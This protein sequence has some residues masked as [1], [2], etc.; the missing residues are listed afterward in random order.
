MSNDSNA[1][2]KDMRDI[3]LSLSLRT[4]MAPEALAV[5]L[6]ELPEHQ[7]V[8]YRA[9]MLGHVWPEFLATLHLGDEYASNLPEVYPYLVRAYLASYCHVTGLPP[10][11]LADAA[12]SWRHAEEAAQPE[13][14][15]AAPPSML[16][17]IADH[18]SLVDTPLVR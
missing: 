17:E 9:R 8:A 2:P 14:A 13:L 16:Q 7:L 5:V 15:P 1:Q 11:V 12:T 4:R 6:N 3:V 10:A 18:F